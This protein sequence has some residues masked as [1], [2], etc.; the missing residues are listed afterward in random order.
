MDA[1]RDGFRKA[2]SEAGQARQ[3]NNLRGTMTKF[4]NV[5]LS[6]ALGWGISPCSAQNAEMTQEQALDIVNRQLQA[7]GFEHGV[8]ASTIA[9][10]YDQPNNE[11]LQH[12]Q[13][14]SF[15]VQVA[16]SLEGRRY[17]MFL[18]VPAPPQAGG[19]VFGEPVCIFVDRDTRAIVPPPDRR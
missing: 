4:V 6:A 1:A 9:R 16:R 7:D 11:C 13:S 15:R 3:Y 18:Y 10:A 8:P 14:E 19:P 12:F 17:F 2:A 5:L